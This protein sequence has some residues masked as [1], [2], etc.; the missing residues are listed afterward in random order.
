MALP[1]SEEHLW[2]QSLAHNHQTQSIWRL[3][4]SRMAGGGLRF[5]KPRE[6]ARLPPPLE[7][8][9]QGTF[10]GG[11]HPFIPPLL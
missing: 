1:W 3:R 10:I 8:A 7:K 9:G 6:K 4:A 5:Q 2:P 11:S